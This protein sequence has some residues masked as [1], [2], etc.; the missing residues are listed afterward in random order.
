MASAASLGRSVGTSLLAPTESTDAMLA[1]QM[2]QSDMLADHYD[3]MD[4]DS[5]PTKGPKP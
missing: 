2:D 5:E 4:E 1:E 3:S